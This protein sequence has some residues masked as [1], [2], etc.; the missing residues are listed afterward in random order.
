MK[1]RGAFFIFF[2]AKSGTAAFLIPERAFFWYALFV[3]GCPF[4][5]KRRRDGATVL[6]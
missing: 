4:A 1:K 3:Y 6:Y 2:V 5:P